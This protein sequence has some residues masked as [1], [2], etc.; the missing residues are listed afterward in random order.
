MSEYQFYEFQAVDRPLTQAEM[1]ELRSYS[2]RA[3]ITPT[4]FIN[5]Y[6]WGNFKGDSDEWMEKYFDAFLYVANWGS[7]RLKFRIPVRLL[8]SEAAADYCTEET[9]FFHS[10]GDHAL[11]SFFSE[12]ESGGWEEGDGWLASLAPVRNDLMRGD[13]RGLYLGWLLAAQQGQLDDDTLEPPVPPGLGE[14][15]EPL[16]GLGDFLRLDEDLI[17]AA[18]EASAPQSATALSRAEMERWAAALSVE[19]REGVV[20]T[21]LLGENPHL[22]EELKQRAMRELHG[23]ASSGDHARRSARRTVGQLL[24]RAQT[25]AA[26]RQKKEAEARARE[27]AKLEREQAEKRE[28]HLVSLIGSEE[29]LWLRISEMILTKQ[30]R[31]YDEAVSLLQDLRDVADLTG[32]GREFISRLWVLRLENTRKPSFIRRLDKAGLMG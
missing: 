3:R 24:A 19:E 28:K 5:E 11:L 14:L 21:L 22:S 25:I 13:Y 17:A 32:Q 27:K 15:S 26:K 6:N 12:D 20:V 29:S 8:D 2:S 23:E 9:F 10:K 7:H 18:A 1:T 4:S 31:R 16:R 30:P